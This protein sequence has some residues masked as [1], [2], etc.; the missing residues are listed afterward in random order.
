MEHA[1]EHE[2]RVHKVITGFIAVPV[3]RYEDTYGKSLPVYKPKTIPPLMEVA[4]KWGLPVQYKQV[5]GGAAYGQYGIRDK[6]ITLATEDPTTFFHELG[7]AADFRNHPEKAGMPT[8]H[9]SYSEGETIA[10]LTAAVLARLY[11][12]DSDAYSWNYLS[13][14]AGS[15][16]PVKV[17]VKMMHV[18]NEVQENVMSILNASGPEHKDLPALV[19]TQTGSVVPVG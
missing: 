14:Y 6:T 19:Q 10:Q 12:Y 15:K 4:K 16:D 1:K 2:L 5:F 8:T 17:G 11:G 9:D 3:F 7:H 13:Y 18:M